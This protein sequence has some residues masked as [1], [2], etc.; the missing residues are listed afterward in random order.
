MACQHL[1]DLLTLTRI[2]LDRAC[3]ACENLLDLLELPP[4]RLY[5]R[6]NLGQQLHN[7]V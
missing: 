5:V 4:I 1:L 2:R 3:M 7:T 6:L